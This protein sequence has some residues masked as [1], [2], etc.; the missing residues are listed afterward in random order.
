MTTPHTP[1]RPAVT[2]PGPWSFPR[3][4]ESTLANGLRVLHHH[5][6]GQH[7]A[8]L[9]LL[10]P[11]PLTAEPDGAE[12]AAAL[13]TAT[14]GEGTRALPGPAHGE[15]VEACGAALEAAAGY[16]HTHVLVDVPGT[17]VA[18]AAA[19]LV[20][21][22]A[23]PE[24]RDDDVERG[25]AVQLAHTAQRLATGAGRATHALR[26]AL[27]DPRH[28]ASRMSSGEPGDVARVT[29]ADVRAL[30]AATFGP[31]GATLV[32]AGDMPPAQV[33]AALTALE[34]WDAGVEGAW[35]HE[36]P[37]PRTPRAWL[38]DR[39]GSVQADL[40]MGWFTIDRA[41]PR[42]AALQI[43]QNALGGAYLSRL[44]R[45][46]RE[47][48][49]FTYGASLVNA[50]LRHG[51]YTYAQGSF[52]TEVVGDAL[53]LM[54]GL[55]DTAATPLTEAEVV[56][57]RDHL[58]GTSPQRYATAAGVAGGVLGLLA[59]GLTPGFVDAQID[60]WRTVTAE[61]ASAA[62]AELLDPRG[63]ALVVVGDAAALA[64]ALAAGGWDAEVLPPDTSP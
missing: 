7:V 12:G 57:A 27:V 38:V 24:L 20:Q 8:S 19:L 60:A 40:R 64:P 34:A 23:E 4:E 16:S 54:P 47:E 43:A 56:R 10:V 45:V 58:V 28:R 46:L 61:Q 13:L 21:A 44:N 17:R 14:L 29:G 33:D 36:H 22:V 25:R 35:R 52:R 48:K 32:L 37:T 2:P 15:A 1:A 31:R 63:R 50:P 39:P 62:A 5:L 9:A 55:V 41:D 6:P 30:H 42:W 51:G 53:A 3:A 11:A 59:A 49:G 26:R 18:E